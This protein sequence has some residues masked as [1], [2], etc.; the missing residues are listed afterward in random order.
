M[1]FTRDV[2]AQLLR[3][4]LGGVQAQHYDRLDYIE[5]MRNSLAAWERRLIE[6]R[7]GEGM[8]ANVVQL[9]GAA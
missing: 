8:A 7:D 6:I 1:G 3:H 4:G 9:R 5:E 2:R